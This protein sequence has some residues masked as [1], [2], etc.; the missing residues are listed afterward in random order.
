MKKNL[1]KHK[2]KNRKRNK[3]HFNIEKIKTGR[4]TNN[5][6]NSKNKKRKQRNNKTKQW[7]IK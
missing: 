3:Q 1:N 2:L 7:K 4:I 6:I 5:R